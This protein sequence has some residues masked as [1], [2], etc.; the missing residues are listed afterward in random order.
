MDG[1]ELY[2]IFEP[3]PDDEY[4]DEMCTAAWTALWSSGGYAECTTSG[5]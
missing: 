3:D 4:Y 2:E 5:L 1:M